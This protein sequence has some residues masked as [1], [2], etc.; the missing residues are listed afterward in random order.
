MGRSSGTAKINSAHGPGT[1][2]ENTARTTSAMIS[3]TIRMPMAA[4][5]WKL[6]ISRLASSIL[7]AST[8]DENANPIP[9]SIA[10]VQSGVNSSRAIGVNKATERTKCKSDTNHM[11]LTDLAQLELQAHGEQ[12]DQNAK[13]GDIIED[14]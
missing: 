1:F 12:Q 5:P 14:R 7:A 4:R 2:P 8:V 9:T 3:C 11:R 13:I 10:T 6:P